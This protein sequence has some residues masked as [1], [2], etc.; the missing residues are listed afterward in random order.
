MPARLIPREKLLEKRRTRKHRYR[1]YRAAT[2][3][4]SLAVLF[5]VPLLGLARFDGWGGEHRMLGRRVGPVEGVFA[6]LVGIAACYLV[7]FLLN[8]FL[9]RMFC[10]WGCP[11]AQVSR[12]GEE[13][14]IAGKTGRRRVAGLFR[15]VGFAVVLAAS[16]L[17]W[18][19]SPR[20]A[21]EGSVRARA[22]A[23]GVFAALVAGA[24]LHGRFWRWDFCRRVCPIGL[25][26]SVVALEK[27]RGIVFDDSKGDCK[28]C[29]VCELVCP[30]AV[31][32]RNLAEARS[33]IGG[34]A[35]DGLPAANH[36]LRCGD[37][38]ELCEFVFK[39]EPEAAVPM[40]FGG[41]T[42]PA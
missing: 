18:W 15:A 27:A 28:D 13:W 36:C 10:G 16:V 1:F 21:F 17:L 26:Y 38:V 6:V 35:I 41:P 40:R 2:I 22:I 39:D 30:V 8:I 24:L 29:R 32:P 14:E 4:V 34:L 31:D 37:C 23:G 9:G 11:V 7:T 42:P 19:V 33:G 3:A 25:Y 20:V 12:F 5:A